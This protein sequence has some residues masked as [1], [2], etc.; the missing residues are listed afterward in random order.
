M[1][2]SLKLSKVDSLFH[3]HGWGEVEISNEPYCTLLRSLRN[4]KMKYNS[5]EHLGRRVWFRWRIEVV[6]AVGTSRIKERQSDCWPFGQRTASPSVND[7]IGIRFHAWF[8]GV[9]EENIQEDTMQLKSFVYF[10]F[11]KISF[12]ISFPTWLFNKE[13]INLILYMKRQI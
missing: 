7:Q 3:F 10:S 11:Q 6:K 12:S 2:T 13:S 8:E 5:R 9:N 4:G 1:V